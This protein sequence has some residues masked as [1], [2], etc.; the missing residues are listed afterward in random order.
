MSRVGAAAFIMAIEAG[1]MTESE[2]ES[3]LNHINEPDQEKAGR[4]VERFVRGRLGPLVTARNS[5]IARSS[6]PLQNERF[7]RGWIENLEL[8]II[9]HDT[10]QYRKEL[11]DHP[12][13]KK[14][15]ERLA[16]ALKNYTG[17]QFIPW[18]IKEVHL[19]AGSIGQFP[20]MEPINKYELELG[21]KPLNL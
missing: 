18:Y 5:E 8:K 7:V 4:S 17:A 10:P 3:L 15:D 21:Y 14:F 20:D 11:A 1:P 6:E 2:R 12:H 19:F 13:D 16:Y 9:L